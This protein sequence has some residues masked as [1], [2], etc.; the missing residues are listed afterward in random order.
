M[1]HLTAT[2]FVFCIYFFFDFCVNWCFK[3]TCYFNLLRRRRFFYFVFFPNNDCFDL[4]Y[5]MWP[6][7]I[8]MFFSYGF[9]QSLQIDAFLSIIYEKKKYLRFSNLHNKGCHNA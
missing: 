4:E 6:E 3:R 9:A 2:D 8:R 5:S 7:M 1:K